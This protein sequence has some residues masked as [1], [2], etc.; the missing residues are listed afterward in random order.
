VVVATRQSLQ[1]GVEVDA[2]F[3]FVFALRGAKVG[4]WHIFLDRQALAAAGLA[5]KK[6]AWRRS[7][8]GSTQAWRP[9]HDVQDESVRA[10]DLPHVEASRASPASCA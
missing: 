3:T 6:R 8:L 7:D 4:A 2:E 10:R 5:S 1:S 9:S